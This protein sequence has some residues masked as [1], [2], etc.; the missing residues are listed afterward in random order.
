M[1]NRTGLIIKKVIDDVSRVDS[2]TIPLFIFI[3]GFVFRAIIVLVFGDFVSP[4]TY[5]Y[6]RIADNIVERNMFAGSA[7][8]GPV[9]LTAFKAPVYPYF[10][11]AVYEIF[12][13]TRFIFIEFFQAFLGALTCVIIY[14]I[15]LKVYGKKTAIIAGLIIAFYPIHAYLSQEISQTIF[16]AFLMPLILLIL[17]HLGEKWK[18]RTAV[19]LGAALGATALLNPAII[20]FA[21]FACFWLFIKYRPIKLTVF[22][23][24]TAIIA[25][26]TVLAIAPWTVRNYKVFHAFIPVKSQFGLN[27]WRG[28]NAVASGITIVPTKGNQAALVDD[29]LLTKTERDVL[30]GMNEVER[31]KR[32]QNITIKYMVD[33]PKRTIA[34]SVKKFCYFWVF[35]KRF[36]QLVINGEPYSRFPLLRNILWLPILITGAFGAFL[37]LYRQKEALL[38]ILLFAAFSILHSLTL[39]EPQYRRT[40]EPVMII[41]SAYAVKNL[42]C[43]IWSYILKI[44]PSL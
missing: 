42:I 22:C 15:T 12:G 38:F 18:T 35:P 44:A 30:A 9:A 31:Y 6:G 1:E 39:V 28:N 23:K 43:R 17:I 37:A 7:H 5:E 13:P 8:L 25:L 10:L 11:A 33:N 41:F 21:P 3:A 19:I 34:L 20:P 36:S 16:F 24:R 2:L 14:M 40:I 32:L 29:L 27:L 4:Q 26:F